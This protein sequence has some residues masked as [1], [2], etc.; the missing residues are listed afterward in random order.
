[1]KH[2]LDDTLEWIWPFLPEPVRLSLAEQVRTCEVYPLPENPT[3]QDVRA[4]G[5]HYECADGFHILTHPGKGPV[6]EAE[7]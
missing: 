1:M 5:L 3:W 7:E 6:A 2:T 4:T